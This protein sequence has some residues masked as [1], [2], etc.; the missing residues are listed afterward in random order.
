MEDS[1]HNAESEDGPVTTHTYTDPVPTTVRKSARI[2]KAP[3]RYG[4]D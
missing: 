3:N 4:W 2:P 1:T